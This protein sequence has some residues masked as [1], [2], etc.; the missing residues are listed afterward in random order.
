MGARRAGEGARSRRGV[1]TG[2]VVMAV[3]G[4]SEDSE[5]E[6]HRADARTT[7]HVKPMGHG[8]L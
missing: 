5:G 3:G 2:A 1:G 4:V 7:G 6:N 8:V